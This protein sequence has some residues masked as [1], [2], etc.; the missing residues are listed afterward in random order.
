MSSLIGCLFQRI[1]FL[2][3]P[4]T[5]WFYFLLF[6]CAP[7]CQITARRRFEGSGS[8][9]T[10]RAETTGHRRPGQ[11]ASECRHGAFVGSTGHHQ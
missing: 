8:E 2:K 11:A 10:D 6:S 4:Q 3:I 1:L 7:R 9:H 5:K